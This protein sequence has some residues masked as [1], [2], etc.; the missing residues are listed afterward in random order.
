MSEHVFILFRRNRQSGL[1][2]VAGVTVKE[3]TMRLFV[4]EETSEVRHAEKWGIDHPAKG[5][6]AKLEE[7]SSG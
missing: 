5:K 6:Q 1:N 4:D 2:E 3:R 7:Y